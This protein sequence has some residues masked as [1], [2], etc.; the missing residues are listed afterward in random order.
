MTGDVDVIP[1]D[2][3]KDAL[4]ELR[5][6]AGEGIGLVERGRKWLRDRQVRTPERAI[7]VIEKLETEDAEELGV[8]VYV[9]PAP[10]GRVTGH[11]VGCEDHGVMPFLAPTRGK[12]ILAAARHLRGEHR[13]TGGTVVLVPTAPRL[14][15]GARS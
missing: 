3:P 15:I 6:M 5:S 12:A 9:W 1:S 8:P 4:E 11:G 10:R 2:L 14:K 7:E 13:Q